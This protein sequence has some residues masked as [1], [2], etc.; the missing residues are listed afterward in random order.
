MFT[1]KALYHDDGT[2]VIVAPWHP[3]F[4]SDVIRRIPRR[5]ISI[6]GLDSH[7]PT[8]GALKG[9]ELTITVAG[10]HTSYA[11]NRFR[12]Y[13]PFADVKGTKIYWDSVKNGWIRAP[14]GGKG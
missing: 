12:L 10:C 2:L 7:E 3:R 4:L 14:A 11:E 13:F 8:A 9:S 6:K 1:C 5:C